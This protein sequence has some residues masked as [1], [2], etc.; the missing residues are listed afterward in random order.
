MKRLVLLGFGL[1]L[2]AALPARSQGTVS[3]T[4]EVYLCADLANDDERLRCFD[5]TVS[6]LR[7][8][9]ASGDIRTIDTA[10]IQQIERDAFGFSL[11][12][13]RTT[14]FGR[15]KNDSAGS[16]DG[17]S[18]KADAMP[19][20]EEIDEVVLAVSR[21][22]KNKVSGRL[23]FVL[24]NGQVW[25]QVDS[26]KLPDGKVKSAKSVTIRRASLGSFL[27]TIDGS[28]AIRVKRIS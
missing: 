13:L 14:L 16:D 7:A 20:P 8:A 26:R 9:E 3:A 19:I 17:A 22:S 11:P 21:A 12:N 23:T 10:S 2:A 24:E 15:T 4:N 18:T 27:M 5:T 1:F 6:K 25:E 28:V